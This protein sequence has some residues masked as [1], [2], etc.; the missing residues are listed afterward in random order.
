MRHRLLF[1]LL[2]CAFAVPVLAQPEGVLQLNDPLHRFLERQQALGRLPGAFLSHQPLSAYEARRYLDSLDVSLLGRIDQQLY[3]RF[4]GEAAGPGVNTFRKIIPFAYRNGNDFFSATDDDY[5]VLLTP[6]AYLQVGQATQSELEGRESSVT[7]WQNTR[8]ARASGHIGKHIFFETRLEENQRRDIRPVYAEDTS[9]RLGFT[10]FNDTTYDY[11]IA[12]GLIGFRSKFFEVR[13]GR[14]R[15]RWDNGNASLILSNYA[16][17]YDQLQ[18]RT[19]FWRL[20]Y[21]NLFA[22]FT[23]KTPREVYSEIVPRKYGAFHRLALSLPGR[24]EIDLF[25]SIIFGSPDTLGVREKGYELA[26]LNP[27]IF[28]R[29]VEHDLVDPSGNSDNALLGGGISWIAYPG[30]RLR[31]E[32][33]IDELKVSQIGE[34]WWGNKWGWTAG[35]DLHDI[36]FSNL[37]LQFEYARLRPFLYSHRSSLSSFTHYNDFLGHPA[38]PNAEDFSLFLDYQPAHRWRIALDASYTRR[39]RDPE[40]LNFGA[41]PLQSHTTRASSTDVFLLQ[42]IRQTRILVE[43]HVGFEFLPDA[44]LALAFRAESVDDEE[45][46]LDRYLIPSLLAR[47]GLPY[48]HLRY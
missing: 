12:T 46:G 37:S 30:I 28:Y 19:T 47:W 13:F 38:G 20:Q 42:G 7:T 32:L 24:V 16:P 23:D 43:G 18:I 11:F 2:L 5:A 44:Y 6:L 29:S 27:L 35:V 8:G 36:L 21:V 4:T 15:N 48:Q 26:Y 1:A 25:E 9:P 14:D 33:L 41:D 31:T 45:R 40:G 22:R 17:V 3:A 34:G 10:K 39:G